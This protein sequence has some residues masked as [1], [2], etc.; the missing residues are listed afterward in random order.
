MKGMTS[1]AGRRKLKVKRKPTGTCG[2]MF[3]DYNRRLLI[4]SQALERIEPPKPFEPVSSWGRRIPPWID[5]K[6]L[7]ED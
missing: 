2:A 3:Q 6:T 1:Q 7:E 4:R 5:P